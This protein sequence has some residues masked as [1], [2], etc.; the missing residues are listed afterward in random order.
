M[1]APTSHPVLKEQGPTDPRIE[2]AISLARVL[3]LKLIDPLIGLVLPGAGDMIS[4]LLGLYLVWV[5]LRIGLPKRVVARMLY[6]LGVDS[7]LGA[8]PAVGDL[9]DLAFRAHARNAE[10]LQDP[11]RWGE[12]GK[13]E[14]LLL[15]GACLVFLVG[16]A[17][18]LALLFAGYALLF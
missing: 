7:L 16:V 12:V 14:V 11:Q 13:L 18:P 17:V 3:D 1:S 15:T 2:R 8:F 6:N 4:S 9:L 5:A 10:L